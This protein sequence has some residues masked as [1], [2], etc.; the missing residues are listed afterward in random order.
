MPHFNKQQLE[1]ISEGRRSP[2]PTPFLPR[3]CQERKIYEDSSNILICSGDAG[4]VHRGHVRALSTCP[5]AGRGR[6]V[7]TGRCQH[8]EVGSPWEELWGQL[9]QEGGTQ[10]PLQG[11]PSVGL[12]QPH[13][14]VLNSSSKKAG[15]MPDVQCVGCVCVCICVCICVCVCVYVCICSSL[16]CM[17][18]HLCTCLCVCVCISVYICVHLCVCTRTACA[19]LR[20]NPTANFIFCFCPL[21]QTI[22][23]VIQYCF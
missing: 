16:V 4:L 12:H 3:V 7:G 13:P 23:Q 10:R 20:F 11:G 19:L 2:S 22:S 6:A 21:Q 1:G 17:C 8:T 9:G 18:A 5:H 14:L 15:E